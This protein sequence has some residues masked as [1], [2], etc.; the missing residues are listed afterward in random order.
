MVFTPFSIRYEIQAL[1][2]LLTDKKLENW[3]LKEATD[4]ELH[5]VA[6]IAISDELLWE[7][8]SDV[9]VGAIVDVYGKRV[10]K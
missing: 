8:Y 7:N 5:E 6:N 10:T 4:D 2:G 3:V 1:E 9:L